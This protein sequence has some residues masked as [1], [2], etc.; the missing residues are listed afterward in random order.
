M[1]EKRY[2]IK[3]LLIMFCIFILFIPLMCIVLFMKTKYSELANNKITEILE[4]KIQQ[5]NTVIQNIMSRMVVMSG[6]LSDNQAVLGYLESQQD[7]Q[8]ILRAEALEQIELILANN[9]DL[10]VNVMVFGEDKMVKTW[11]GSAEDSGF[12]QEIQGELDWYGSQNNL[13]TWFY[14]ETGMFDFYS[15]G[16]SRSLNLLRRTPSGQKDYWMIVSIDL[17]TINDLLFGRDNPDRELYELGVDGKKQKIY[18]YPESLGQ[19]AGAD[20]YIESLRQ[21]SF[22]QVDSSFGGYGSRF[23][24]TMT[25]E[26]KNIE[27]ELD[28]L[29]AVFYGG[30]VMIF[31]VFTVSLFIF[32]RYLTQPISRL[33]GAMEKT[34]ETQIY[35][36][37]H[38][39]VNISE[40]AA[41]NS[42]YNIMVRSINEYIEKV[43][44]QEHE[45]QRLH[46][47][48]LQMQINPHFLFNTLN[49]I[50]WVCYSNNDE[51]A[52][53]LIASLGKMYEISM[54][55]GSLHLTMKEEREFILNYIA[56]MEN[57]YDYK[58]RAEFEMEKNTEDVIIL[59]F[60][61]QPIVENIF[62]HGFSIPCQERKIRI[63]TCIKDEK[64]KITVTDNGSGIEEKQLEELRSEL[65]KCERV[66]SKVGI[67]NVNHRIQLHYGNEYGLQICNRQDGVSGTE[68]NLILPVKYREAGV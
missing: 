6:M 2:T 21:E 64:L 41:L 58:V 39:K 1:K 51:K 7:D 44:S 11:V 31:A 53:N 54:N 40:I 18:F 42:W 48:M 61:L 14:D 9:F 50:K 19:D 16:T 59:K 68:V 33:I 20:D 37:L 23:L 10:P 46:F 62:L 27:V 55:K 30:T 12:E 24:S 49:S 57:R 34:K 56:L 32:I 15:A 25:V 65:A 43:K 17:D 4:S 38:Q 29:N 67:I 63:Y 60:L 52:G 22:Y 36:P 28:E 47:Q 13:V 8:E 35:L 26:S 5:N 45:K 66:V 3:Q